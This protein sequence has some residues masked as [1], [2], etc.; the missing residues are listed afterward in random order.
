MMLEQLSSE[1]L[2]WGGTMR[3]ARCVSITPQTTQAKTDEVTDIIQEGDD[4][5]VKKQRWSV[6]C[7]RVVTVNILVKK[8]YKLNG[9]HEIFIT[10]NLG[11]LNHI[12]H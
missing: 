10:T 6:W 9:I 12:Y 11:F 8:N 1:K 2:G 4:I 3:S 7:G 5:A